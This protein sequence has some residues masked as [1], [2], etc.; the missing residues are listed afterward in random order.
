VDTAG[1]RLRSSP[2][3]LG[4]GLGLCAGHPGRRRRWLVV[5]ATRTNA[6]EQGDQHPHER[7]L[8]VRVLAMPGAH[9]ARALDCQLQLVESRLAV[10]VE[11]ARR[12]Q[13]R[14]FTARVGN[15]LVGVAVLPVD[16]EL[17]VAPARDGPEARVGLAHAAL[18]AA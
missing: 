8:L 7:I 14:G 5:L 9:D 2:G 4:A 17:Q 12:T 18:L 15:V 3:V 16:G 11:V 6:D 13:D 10:A 1:A